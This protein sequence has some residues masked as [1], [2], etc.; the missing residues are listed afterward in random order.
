MEMNSQKN[1]PRR[2]IGKGRQNYNRGY[3]LTNNRGYTQIARPAWQFLEPH[4]YLTFKYSDFQTITLLTVTG[5]SQIYNL[6]SLFDPDRTGTGHQPY[7]YDQL[8]A[9]YNRYR[10][11]RVKWKVKFATSSGDYFALVLPSNGLLA[12]APTTLAPFITASECPLSKSIIQS[13]TSQSETVIGSIKLNELN[14]VTRTEYIA[15]DRFEAQVSTSPAELIV[16]NLAFY[17]PNVG[18]TIINFN[19]TLE[20]EADLHDPILLAGS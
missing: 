12:S 4:Q 15:D 10:V 16:L 13:S 17:N 9:M 14:G 19:V 5:V 7:G 11:L 3:G 6:N 2:R 20:Y 1:Q 18:T 8:S